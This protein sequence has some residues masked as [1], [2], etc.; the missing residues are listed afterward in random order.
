MGKVEN[1][2]TKQ[3]QQKMPETDSWFGERSQQVE[4]LQV[5]KNKKKTIFNSKFLGTTEKTRRLS[6][7][8]IGPQTGTGDLFRRAWPGICYVG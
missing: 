1:V 3:V 6:W 8:F 4:A 2:I 5:K 7:Q